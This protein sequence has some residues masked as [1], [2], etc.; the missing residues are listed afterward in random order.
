MGEGRP[1][2]E[3]GELEPEPDGLL[4]CPSALPTASDQ[5]KTGVGLFGWAG[6]IVIEGGATI[7]KGTGRLRRLAALARPELECFAAV[8]ALNILLSE[9]DSL[10]LSCC[11]LNKEPRRAGRGV[12][13]M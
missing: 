11:G 8:R 4:L 13:S 6:S 1:G 10:A 2:D 9:S 5:R 3:A 7:C 12:R